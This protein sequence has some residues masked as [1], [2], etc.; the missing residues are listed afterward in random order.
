MALTL[1]SVPKWKLSNIAHFCAVTYLEY[2]GGMK[3]MKRT[4]F[5]SAPKWNS[6]NHDCGNL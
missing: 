6:V 2:R 3:R 4:Y 5:G 1:H